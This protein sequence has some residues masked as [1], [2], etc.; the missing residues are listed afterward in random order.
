MNLVTSQLKEVS[1]ISV[2]E[3]CQAAGAVAIID[4]KNICTGEIK[5]KGSGMGPADEYNE[6]YDRRCKLADVCQRRRCQ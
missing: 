1:G 4:S 5:V 6:S 2:G 3:Y